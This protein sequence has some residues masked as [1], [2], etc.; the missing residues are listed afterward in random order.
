MR[1]ELNDIYKFPT[2]GAKNEQSPEDQRRIYYEIIW[3][4]LN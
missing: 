4:I 1:Q 2:A 3:K